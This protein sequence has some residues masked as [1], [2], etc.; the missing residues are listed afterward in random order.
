[1]LDSQ[2]SDLQRKYISQFKSKRQ[3]NPIQLNTQDSI[4]Q[5]VALLKGEYDIKVFLAGIIR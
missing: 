4:D 5:L 2:E 3:V 1:M